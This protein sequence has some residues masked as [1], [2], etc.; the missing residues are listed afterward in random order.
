MEHYLLI[1]VLHALPGILLLLGVLAHAFMLWKA[2]RGGDKAVLQ[3]KLQRTRTI[4]LPVFAVLALSLP[5]TGWW[6]VNLAGWPLSQLW[7]L[8][9][10]SLFGVLMIVGLLLLGRLGAWQAQVDGA[11]PA[12]SLRFVVAYAALIVVLLVVIMAVMGAKPV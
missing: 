11:V 5:V 8:L 2:W 9:G 10:S 1:R 4:S 6:M 3:R 7:L 12:K